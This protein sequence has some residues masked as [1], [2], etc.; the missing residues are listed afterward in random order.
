M[1][2]I[3][4]LFLTIFFI[5]KSFHATLLVRDNCTQP[6]PEIGSLGMHSLDVVVTNQIGGHFETVHSK[7][8]QIFAVIKSH[9][10]ATI[11]ATVFR[12]E[13]VTHVESLNDTV[14]GGFHGRCYVCLWICGFDAINRFKSVLAKIFIFCIL[15]NDLNRSLLSFHL[16]ILTI[17][18]NNSNNAD[19]NSYDEDKR[20]N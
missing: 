4:D 19:G 14:R 2:L 18:V 20:N 17:F 11:L 6:I 16:R 1:K 9:L 13:S 10:D 7:L 12:G 15:T 3:L 8:Q 5:I